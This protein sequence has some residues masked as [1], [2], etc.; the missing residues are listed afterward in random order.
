M[1]NLTVADMNNNGFPDLVSAQIF[2]DFEAVKLGNGDGTFGASIISDNST[3][4]SFG[5]N[6]LAVAD[7][8][9]DGLMDVVTSYVDGNIVVQFASLALAG[10]GAT[11]TSSVSSAVQKSRCMV[12]LWVVNSP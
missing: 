8:N 6:N 1:T 11:P 5:A 12:A 3:D 9:G 7:L 2:G 10:C 4:S